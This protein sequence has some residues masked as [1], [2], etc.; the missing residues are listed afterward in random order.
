[1]RHVVIK[2]KLESAGKL[3]RIRIFVSFNAGVLGTQAA[4]E[5]VAKGDDGQPLVYY[6]DIADA[7][8]FG[9]ARGLY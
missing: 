9:H 6:N 2:R 5:R 7:H 4:A 1:L 3:I 8:E